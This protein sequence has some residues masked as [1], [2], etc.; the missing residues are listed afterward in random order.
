M[1]GVGKVTPIDPL[2]MGVG[3]KRVGPA[4]LRTPRWTSDTEQGRLPV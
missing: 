4:R 1:R 3:K 2:P